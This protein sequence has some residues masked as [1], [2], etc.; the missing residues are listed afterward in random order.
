M[1]LLLYPITNMSLNMKYW[2]AISPLKLKTL[3]YQLICVKIIV[4]QKPSKMTIKPSQRVNFL[5]NFNRRNNS[6]NSRKR[7]RVIEY[8]LKFAPMY[9]YISILMNLKAFCV[10]QNET[11]KMEKM[12][13]STNKLSHF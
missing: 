12:S 4:I 6:I 5:Y 13:V 9:I 8:L 2:R 7:H 3:I 1:N 11:T 10:T